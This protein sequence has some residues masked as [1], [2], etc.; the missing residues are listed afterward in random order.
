MDFLPRF[1]KNLANKKIIELVENEKLLVPAG[2]QISTG[3]N[4]FLGD[5]GSILIIRLEI[6]IFKLMK[7]CLIEFKRQF[8]VAD[9]EIM[10]F[11]LNIPLGYLM[12][13]GCTLTVH[14]SAV[15]IKNRAFIFSGFSNSGKSTVLSKLLSSGRM[16]SEDVCKIE[17]TEG[18]YTV[19][20]SH[21]LIK[22]KNSSF[23]SLPSYI[24]EAYFSKTDKRGRGHYLIHQNRISK[25]IRTTID[26]LIVLKW[27]NQEQ[28]NFL[29]GKEAFKVLLPH[30]FKA[31]FNESN[32]LKI[33]KKIQASNFMRATSL[34]KYIKILEY[35]RPK[36]SKN[37]MLYEF[38]KI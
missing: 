38:L 26:S 22:I 19:V 34:I 11:L 13:Q 17:N 32:P 33:S 4:Y 31:P 27:G 10:A 15:N 30:V 24:S 29:H 6:G 16:I 37:K 12:F 23:R 20:N 25:K 35:K 18:Q 36:N 9:S 1:K 3:E 8:N 7:G 28:L 21:P 5:G 14:G 2:I